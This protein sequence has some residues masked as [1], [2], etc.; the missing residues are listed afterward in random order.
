MPS[1][2]GLDCFA[3]IVSLE[4]TKSILLS[5]FDQFLE[6]LT[7]EKV[8]TI[9]CRHFSIDVIPN[10]FLKSEYLDAIEA[11]G[12]RRK[13]IEATRMTHISQIWIDHVLTQNFEC[14]VNVL[15]QQS[16]SE[17]VALKVTWNG[18]T[19]ETNFSSYWGFCFLKKAEMFG[20]YS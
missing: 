19:T 12:F 7:S 17:H 6:Q 9:K 14:N 16:F 18:R 10:N 8:P 3:F 13:S 11:N 2:S 1:A 5:F 4:T 15:K 20:R